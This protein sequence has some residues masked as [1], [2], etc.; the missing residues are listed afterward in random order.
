MV[1]VSAFIL[2]FHQASLLSNLKWTK[3]IKRWSRTTLTKWSKSSSR[4]LAAW[5]ISPTPRLTQSK[6]NQKQNASLIKFTLVSLQH[7]ALIRSRELN[8]KPLKE[9]HDIGIK[10]LRFVVRNLL[11][12][13]S[14]SSVASGTACRYSRRVVICAIISAST[15]AKDLSHVLSAKRRSHKAVTWAV[16]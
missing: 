10:R 7:S 3:N 11:R 5:E 16:T 2:I 1:Q 9:S 6:R 8:Q 14:T 12:L 4:R 13:R 15:Q